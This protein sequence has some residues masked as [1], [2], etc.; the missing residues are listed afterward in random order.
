VSYK[1]TR[2]G[3]SEGPAD[4][5]ATAVVEIGKKLCVKYD[6]FEG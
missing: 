6:F 1:S 4:M 5:G 2:S 3:K